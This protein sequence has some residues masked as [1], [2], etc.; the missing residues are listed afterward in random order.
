MA[1][2][3]W[4]TDEEE[5]D[6]SLQVTLTVPGWVD[7][8]YVAPTVPPQGCVPQDLYDR[9]EGFRSGRERV[10]GIGHMT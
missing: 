9:G 5:S 8:P 7:V 10:R 1:Y 4:M 2:V 3:T 6:G